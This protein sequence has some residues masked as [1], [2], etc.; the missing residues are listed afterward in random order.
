M[1]SIELMASQ[2]TILTTL[3][4][5]HRVSEDTVKGETIAEEIDRNPG[6]IHNQMQSLKTL[7]LV[8]GVPGP[9]GGY[10]PTSAAYEALDVQEMDEPATVLLFHDSERITE[11]NVAEINLSSVQHPDQCRAEI[12]VHG[13]ISDIHESDTI[14]VGTTPLSNLAVEG[15]VDGKDTTNNV[16][17]IQLNIITAP[18]DTKNHVAIPL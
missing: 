5:L 10:K 16:L 8:E 14:T 17:I 2:Q 6:T 9:E 3:T 4:E 7:Q 11:A 18:A 1:S 12:Y 13:S 15:T